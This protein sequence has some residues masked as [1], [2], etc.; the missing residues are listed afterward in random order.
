MAYLIFERKIPYVGLYEL[1]GIAISA[2]MRK[3]SVTTPKG[4]TMAHWAYETDGM[5]D[6]EPASP[7]VRLTAWII[8]FLIYFFVA[9]VAVFVPALMLEIEFALIPLALVVSFIL[10]IVI[11]LPLLGV[12]AVQ[13]V[14]LGARGQTFGKIIMKI[15]IVDAVTGEQPQWARL[16]SLRNI[17][18]WFIISWII[19]TQI[20]LRFFGLYVEFTIL[21]AGLALGCA[22]CMVDSLFIFR[23]DHRTIHDLIAGTRVDKVA[24]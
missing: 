22:Y 21:M 6:G 12:F 16:I 1:E 8:D 2:P 14:L 18:S 23:A 13:M 9:I 7:W 24:D 20:I 4:L 19:L 17:V 3:A 5:L 11:L 15:R 10:L